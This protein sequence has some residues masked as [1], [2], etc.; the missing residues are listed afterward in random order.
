MSIYAKEIPFN[1]K[2]NPT[3]LVFSQSVGQY[4]GVP[5]ERYE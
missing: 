1:T 5:L 3:G 4:V 2:K